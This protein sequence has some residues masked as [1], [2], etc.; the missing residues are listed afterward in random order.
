MKRMKVPIIIAV[1]LIMVGIL[2]AIFALD[3]F[4]LISQSTRRTQ[5][6]ERKWEQRVEEQK[7]DRQKQARKSIYAKLSDENSISMAIIGDNMGFQLGR[8]TIETGWMDRLQAYI[9]K[10]YKS[11]YAV[12]DYSYYDWDVFKCYYDF[13]RQKEE[14]YDLVFLF[15]GY[16]EMQT[17]SV[18]EF[19]YFYE[20]LI[21]QIQDRHQASR[22][23]RRV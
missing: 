1:F 7:M 18:K 6:D 9:D 11:E 16:N 23:L 19:E 22:L 13:M 10:I 4:N 8:R 3:H 20:A 12:Y 17:M 14:K 15:F 21:R 5:D 2:A